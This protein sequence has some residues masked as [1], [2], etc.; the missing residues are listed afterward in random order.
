FWKSLERR[1]RGVEGDV[2]KEWLGLVVLFDEADRFVAEKFCGVAFVAAN[3]VVAMPVETAVTVMRE[4]IER[5]VEMAV[6]MVEAA[7]RGQVDALKMTKMPL[8][9]DGSEVAGILQ[10]LG[11]RPF[12][13]WEA[14]LGPGADD[15]NLEA[16]AHRVTAGHER[17]AGWRTDG[18]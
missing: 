3:G 2:E 12:F 7:T 8:A 1:V 15:T 17:R 4:I 13:E 16:V 6:L 5:A 9:T 10:G 18:L 11:K 14:V